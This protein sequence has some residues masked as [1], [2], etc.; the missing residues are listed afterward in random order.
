MQGQTQRDRGG[1]GGGKP[2]K[3]STVRRG[4][5]VT[6]R[7]GSD[8]DAARLFMGFPHFTVMPTRSFVLLSRASFAGMWAISGGIR[9]TMYSHLTTAPRLEWYETFFWAAGGGGQDEL[10]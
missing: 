5:E 3:R 9:S 4:A 1:G 2:A 7:R 8:P 6:S 10:A